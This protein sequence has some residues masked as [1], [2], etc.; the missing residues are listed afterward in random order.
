METAP[1]IVAKPAWSEQPITPTPKSANSI[2]SS[3]SVVSYSFRFFFRRGNYTTLVSLGLL[4]LYELVGIAYYAGGQGWAVGDVIYFSVVVLTTVGYGDILPS[5]D[6][7]KMFTCFYALSAL[8]I[9]AC[10]VSNVMD[11]IHEYAAEKA[12]E[13]RSESGDVGIFE[14]REQKNKERRLAML[15]NLGLFTVLIALGT[16]VFG[17]GKDWAGEESEGSD[18]VNA[19]YLSVITLTTMGFGDFSSTSDGEKAF[20]I[21]FMI[22]GIPV[23]AGCLGTFTEYIFGE[24]KDEIQLRLIKG[25]M[26]SEKFDSMEEFCNKLS[27]VGAKHERKSGFAADG[28][29]SEIEFLSFV[30]VENGVAT[31]DQ[32]KDAMDN[33]A[34]LDTSQ[35]RQIGKDDFEAWLLR[36][37]NHTPCPNH[38]ARLVE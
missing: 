32:I 23:F 2:S 25:G 12:A 30:L 31:I 7:E 15:K 35:D 20:N 11:A 18:W 33:F 10:A 29:I 9:A 27:S 6:G 37:K 38:D 17:T 19:F 5:T 21:F 16:V 36:K 34:E 28:K 14:G 3:T 24:Q 1:D 26:C 13:A 22:I 8:V 4:V